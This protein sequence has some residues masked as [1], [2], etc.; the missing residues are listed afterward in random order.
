MKFKN[1]TNKHKRDKGK[2]KDDG[3]REKMKKQ[4]RKE[5]LMRKHTKNDKDTYYIGKGDVNCQKVVN[6]E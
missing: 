6:S 2:A 5:K 4:E 1:E 3:Q